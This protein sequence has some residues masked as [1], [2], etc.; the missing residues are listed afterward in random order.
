MP[1]KG[2]IQG[3]REFVVQD[4]AEVSH[5]TEGEAHFLVKKSSTFVVKEEEGI[6]FTVIDKGATFSL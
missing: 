1:G 4:T 5:A 6:V 2:Q 3:G